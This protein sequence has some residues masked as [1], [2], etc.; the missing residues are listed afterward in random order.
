MLLLF[1]STHY[2]AAAL[3][4][5]PVVLVGPFIYSILVLLL[6]IPC[7]LPSG[8]VLV[9]ASAAESLHSPGPPPV[10]TE[11][12][13]RNDIEIEEARRVVDLSSRVV[14]V[15][16]EAVIRNRGKF[17]ISKIDWLFS[18]YEAARIGH[19]TVNN[20][21][22][23]SLEISRLPTLVQLPLRQ[24]DNTLIPLVHSSINATTIVDSSNE[25]FFSSSFGVPPTRQDGYDPYP[26]FGMVYTFSLVN[27]PDGGILPGSVTQLTIM[28]YLGLMIYPVPR[29]VRIGAQSFV[30]FYCRNIILSP[31]EVKLQSTAYKL[32][33]PPDV[34]NLDELAHLSP[35]KIEQK[36]PGL[37][38][39]DNIENTSRFN[40]GSKIRIHYKL[41]K[42]LGLLRK[43][44]RHIEVSHWGNV[45]FHEYY[46][47]VNLAAGLDGEFSR[48]E[49]AKF[50]RQ[51]MGRI[52]ETPEWPPSNILFE[53]EA[54]LP[55]RAFGLE[56]F[57]EIGN[58]SSS[59]AS[60]QG[61]GPAYTSMNI[62]P[63]FPLFGG[64][65]TDFQIQYHTPIRNMLSVDRYS[66]THILN[67]TF[68]SPFRGIFTEDLLTKVALPA[69]AHNIRI[70]TPREI[71]GNW[72][73]SK[74]S[75]FDI[76]Q[77]RPVVCIYTHNY[78]IPEKDL[79][80][81]KFQILYNYTAA[82]FAVIEK[83]L[84]ISMMIL[85]PFLIWIFIGRLNTRLARKSESK[86][87]DRAD[88]RRSILEHLFELYED[89][90]DATDDF[91]KALER[92]SKQPLQHRIE[93]IRAP[94]R[95][96]VSSLIQKAGEFVEQLGVSED[97]LQR[98]PKLLEELFTAT[99]AVVDD[100]LR[101]ILSVGE[102]RTGQKT[103]HATIISPSRQESGYVLLPATDTEE[104]TKP[105]SSSNENV[106]ENR[107][108]DLEVELIT[109]LETSSFDTKL[110]SSL[111]P[112]TE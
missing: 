69:G 60:R 3:A 87:L 20:G 95:N 52:R 61:A 30:E 19:I 29:A 99:E 36:Q 89:L 13:F 110:A 41:Q 98:I 76:I 39:S 14:K 94:W 104:L 17:K 23:P 74:W 42:H 21:R 63:R 5:M 75:W 78:F 37:L 59:T 85:I 7:S 77:S 80:Q 18:A 56:Y 32:P 8:G 54:A 57:D 107:M 48:F 6:S 71:D 51:V 92:F 109:L 93:A 4:A 15:S 79:L 112:K 1:N 31:Y 58:I 38:V 47:L 22:G 82:G 73:E 108:I 83:P 111:R 72:T 62:E 35:A 53:L 91:F 26:N 40:V 103:S 55:R 50:T 96:T 33:N 65:K 68:G 70:R 81:Y 27:T 12:D 66:D 34:N 88:L 10:F 84:I 64:W 102:R 67:V 9:S 25:F 86:E 24:P 90:S 11:R 106:I 45:F 49:Y 2:P 28:V 16:T 97:T 101:K 44:E 43:A 105:Q 100:R 46:D